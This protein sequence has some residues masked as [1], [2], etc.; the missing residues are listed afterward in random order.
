ME[1]HLNHGSLVCNDCG[2]GNMC[3]GNG[4]GNYN[5]GHHRYFFLR[6]IIGICI[7]M[8]VFALGV[9]IGEFKGMFERDDYDGYMIRQQGGNYYPPHY[10]MFN[11]RV[12][13]VGSPLPLEQ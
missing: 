11:S 4:C 6:L 2:Q 9:K 10:M 7:I 5:P 12:M 1:Q 8:I 3:C 13:P